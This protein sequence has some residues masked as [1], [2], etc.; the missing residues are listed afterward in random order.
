MTELCGARWLTSSTLTCTLE[1][2]HSGMHEADY[3]IEGVEGVGGHAWWN[4]EPVEKFAGG[5]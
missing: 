2:G 1:K 4:G 3:A 5:D